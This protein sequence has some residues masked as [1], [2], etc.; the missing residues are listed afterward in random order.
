MIA[1]NLVLSPQTGRDGEEVETPGVGDCSRG[2]GGRRSRSRLRTR[3][4]QISFLSR[5]C[6][7][8]TISQGGEGWQ[9]CAKACKDSQNHFEWP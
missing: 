4:W 8:G 9:R 6:Y 2:W 7:F 5:K 3:T 1:E